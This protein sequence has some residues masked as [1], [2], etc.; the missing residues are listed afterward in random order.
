[1]S[2]RLLKDKE[3]KTN[4]QQNFGNFAESVNFYIIS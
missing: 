2:Y 3:N 4:K 1:M